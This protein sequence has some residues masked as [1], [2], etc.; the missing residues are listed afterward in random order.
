MKDDLTHQWLVDN[1]FHHHTS[2]RIDIYS[3][4]GFD[5][6][7]D[8]GTTPFGL[9]IRNFIKQKPVITI[10]DMVDLHRIISGVTIPIW[11]GMNPHNT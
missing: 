4:D 1:K 5:Y 2:T 10:Q 9:R 7:Y 11:F 8:S 6:I 3:R